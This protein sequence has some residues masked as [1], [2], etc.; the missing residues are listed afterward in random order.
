MSKKK[1]SVIQT[2]ASKG[3]IKPPPFVESGTQYETMMGSV[4]YGV[5]SDTS[6]NDVY[7]FCMPPKDYVFP[8]LA[9]HIPGFSTQVQKFDQYQQHHIIDKETRKE[10]DMNIYG[11][12]KY[13]KL[14]MD[15]NPNMIDSLFTAQNMVLSQTRIG[16][17]VRDNR[18]IFLSKKAWH[19]FKGYSY[20]QM[21]KMKVKN[22]DPTSTRYEMVQKY[23][24]DVKFAYHVV[25]L[26]DEV[27][28]ILRDGDIDLMRDRERLKSIR[29]GEWKLEDIEQ[30][31]V[32]NEKN[33][34]KL[35]E[36]S[37]VV[38]N[39]PDEKKI[40]Q[41]LVDCLEEY[42]GDISSAVVLPSEEADVLKTIKKLVER[43]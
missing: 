14:C 13:F 38:P 40:R 5:S 6:D 24:Y 12:V 30:F 31:F 8:H 11:I 35:Y 29:R 37:T 19:S 25:R 41:L 36:E 2:L 16:Q 17:M 9:G 33:M 21:H 4:A 10:Y 7:G 1:N 43:F 28:Q 18:R 34:W 39:R 23:G 27:E 22:P 32:E 3:L 26:L 20:S 42:Y 15:N